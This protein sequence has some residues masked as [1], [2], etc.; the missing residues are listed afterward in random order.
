MSMEIHVFFS[1]LPPLPLAVTKAMEQLGLD[2]AISDPDSGFEL[3]GFMPMTNGSGM[4][5][6]ETGTE[7]YLGSAKEMID[8]L[9]IE[10]I[11]PKLEHEISFRWGSDFMEGA[12]AIALS[13][14]IAKLTNGVIWED[15]SG[16]VLSIENAVEIC[17]EMTAAG[18]RQ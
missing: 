18:K 17:H 15:S 6:I 14:A 12:C 13:A 1:G 2:F 9:G 16:E 4:G 7:V 5:A 11:D 8:A 3:G 10:G